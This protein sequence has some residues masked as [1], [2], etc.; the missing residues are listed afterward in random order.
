MTQLFG[1]SSYC[2]VLAGLLWLGAQACHPDDVLA[3][4][5]LNFEVSGC[6][7]CLSSGAF[8]GMSVHQ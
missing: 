8:D 4:R 6:S 7:C 1:L 5:V 2:L 3:G